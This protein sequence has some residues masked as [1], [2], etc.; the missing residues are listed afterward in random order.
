MTLDGYLKKAVEEKWAVPHLNIATFEQLK[1]MVEA[2]KR[3]RSPLHIGTS[4]G[5]SGH[6]GLRQSVALAHSF[7]EESGV[8]IFLNADH[9]HSVEEA[10]T[11][12]DAG[13]DSIGI[14]LSAKSYE[15]NIEGT[16]EIVRYAKAKNPHISVEGELGYLRGS[17][18]IQHEVIDIRPEDMTDPTQAQE[19]VKETGVHRFAPAIGNI[20]GIAA[21]KP[22]LDFSRIEA[23]RALIPDDVALVLHGGSGISDADVKKAIQ[24]G[25][26][27]VHINTEIRV[28]YTQALRAF[29]QENP[30]ETTPYKIFPS[31]LE[32]IEKKVEEKIKLFGSEN[33]I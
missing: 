19:F 9:F 22:N 12:I 25:M 14:D 31:V 8:P 33:K 2:A 20:H 18:T 6:M 16:K 27:N 30:N 32:A 10:K 15:E 24:S 17:S 3:L 7:Y 11:A 4:T 13:Y 28:A 23:I 1:A 5:E 21:N 29:L 26:N